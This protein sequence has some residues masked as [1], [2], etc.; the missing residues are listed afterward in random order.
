MS[1][2]AVVLA[3]KW[4]G[5]KYRTLLNY[6]LFRYCSKSDVYPECIPYRNN[7]YSYSFKTRCKAQYGAAVDIRN[8]MIHALSVP[9]ITDFYS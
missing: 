1:N 2:I 5:L 3:G 7:S 9:E 6:Y 4:L 8:I